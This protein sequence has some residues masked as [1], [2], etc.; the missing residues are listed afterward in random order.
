M[1]WV[2]ISCSVPLEFSCE[3]FA[4]KFH[5][6]SVPALIHPQ[7]GLE[8]I[9]H[10]DIEILLGI[11][12]LPAF[13]IYINNTRLQM[14]ITVC[15]CR[16][17]VLTDKWQ[18]KIVNKTENC[19][20][21]QNYLI[22]KKEKKIPTREREITKWQLV[23]YMLAIDNICGFF[24]HCSYTYEFDISRDS[25]IRAQNCQAALHAICTIETDG[26]WW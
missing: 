23:V 21:A 22:Q 8:Q 1:T 7:F 10:T 13:A 25:R 2:L 18:L 4:F 9:S 12:Y 15:T 11:F 26:Y 14:L 19:A 5:A 24:A 20:P 16:I 17:Q 3:F 6:I